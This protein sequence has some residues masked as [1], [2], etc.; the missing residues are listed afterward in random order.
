MKDEG[1]EPMNVVTDCTAC[2]EYYQPFF[3]HF[4]NFRVHL[5]LESGF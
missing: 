2:L 3:E 4:I 1:V 5:G